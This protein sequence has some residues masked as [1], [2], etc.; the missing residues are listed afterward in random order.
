MLPPQRH[1]N[2]TG[3]IDDHNHTAMRPCT[4]YGPALR[5]P[6]EAHSAHHPHA[7]QT[8]STD[9]RYTHANAQMFDPTANT[10][11]HGNNKTGKEVKSILHPDLKTIPHQ[12]EVQ[13]IGNGKVPGVYEGLTEVSAC[14]RARVCLCAVCGMDG[15]DSC[16]AKWVVSPYVRHD[17]GPDSGLASLGSGT[18]KG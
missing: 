9:T 4:R 5:T 10:Y 16:V 11:G 17:R 15:P 7:L 2:H 13:L 3:N 1:Q 6:M 8:Y 14:R 12:P 18:H